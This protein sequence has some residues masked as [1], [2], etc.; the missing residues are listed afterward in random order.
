[1]KR[2]A[3]FLFM[4]IIL[5][6]V[7][8]LTLHLS[9]RKID[10]ADFHLKSPQGACRPLSMPES[11][12]PDFRFHEFTAWQTLST[13]LVDRID[14]PMG[15]ENGALVY[16][17]Q[18]F[19]EMNEKRGGH[20]TGDDLN[21][22]GGMNTDLGDPV[23]AAAEGLVVY[24]GI[25][26][27]G[28]GSVLILAHRLA[29]GRHFQSMYAHLH[30]IDVALGSVVARGQKI[31]SVG[32]AEGIYPAHLHYEIRLGHGI[33]IGAGYA[34]H[35]LNRVDP[36]SFRAPLAAATNDLRPAVSH[37]VQQATRERDA[38]TIFNQL[39]NAANRDKLLE[40]L[41]PQKD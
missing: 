8:A 38:E 1:M 41:Q 39:N 24:S 25:P 28:W 22:I 21:G 18:P 37:I 11:G 3:L 31:A 15:S 9:Q 17:A 14:S 2:S 6:M 29:D 19:W 5:A 10:L 32:T 20:H 12:A 16:N 33:D 36:A 26:S 23:F 4:L 40:I 27:P 13:P 34:A 30:K 35:P 7:I